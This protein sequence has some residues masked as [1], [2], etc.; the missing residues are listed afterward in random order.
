MVKKKEH[1]LALSSHHEP[2]SVTSDVQASEHTLIFK[3]IYYVSPFRF[4]SG[5][6]TAVL[7][8][9]WTLPATAGALGI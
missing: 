6:R 2:R 9:I 3:M 7:I 4:S 1:S 5:A 8:S